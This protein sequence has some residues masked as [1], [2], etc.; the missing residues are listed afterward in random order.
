M[1]TCAAVDQNVIRYHYDLST[2][3][4]RLMWGRHIHHGLW[5]ADE[6]PEVAQLQLT[7]MLAAKAGI[8]AGDRVADVGCGMGGSSIYLARQGCHVDGITISPFQR[9]WASTAARWHGV[10]NQTKF[11]CADAE[12]FE[13]PAGSLDVVWSIECTE[14]LFDKGAFFRR[15]SEWLKPGGRVAICAWLAGPQLHDHHEDRQRVQQVHDVCEGFYCPSL[16]T[17]HD[18][19]DWMTAAGLQVEHTADL[20]SQVTRTWEICQRR[21]RWSGVRWMTPLVDR[22]TG[23]FLDRFQTILD[24][25]RSG[26]MQYGCL[27]ARK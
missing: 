11:H 24:A 27:V 26:A 20:T 15:V 3:F 7:Q 2:V 4:Y 23:M 21:V 17:M 12:K 9:R 22:T 19:A 5:E 16:G 1:I 25:Y 14:H 6:S 18:Y 8:R 10:S 13:L